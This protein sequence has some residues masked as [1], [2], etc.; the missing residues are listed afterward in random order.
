[1]FLLVSLC[2]LTI[3]PIYP[4][5]FTHAPSSSSPPQVGIRSEARIEPTKSKAGFRLFTK[6]DKLGKSGM[7]CYDQIP[8]YEHTFC[9]Q[10]GHLSPAQWSIG[11]EMLI[12]KGVVRL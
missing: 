4:S 10:C 3:Y 5:P 7:C 6:K 8:H 11:C 1:M 9:K 2:V 12:G